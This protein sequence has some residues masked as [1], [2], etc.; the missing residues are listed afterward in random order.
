M[1]TGMKRN[2]AIAWT[3]LI[4]LLWSVPGPNLPPGPIGLDKLV[5][6]A[7][8]LGFTILWRRAYPSPRSRFWI[9][10]LGI[11]YGWG[12]EVYQGTLIPGR[13]ADA[14]DAIANAMG[15]GLGLLWPG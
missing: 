3:V 6:L 1:K 11:L 7:L 5:H 15:V 12:L 13:F 9:G 14:Q 2:V 8:F 10:G 4:L